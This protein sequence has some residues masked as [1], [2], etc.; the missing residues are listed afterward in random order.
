MRI[1]LM[2]AVAAACV[3]GSVW[4]DARTEEQAEAAYSARIA[5]EIAASVDAAL[6]DALFELE[7]AGLAREDLAEVRI[8]I[9][10]ARAEVR[11]ELAGLDG[12]LAG[13]DE[14]QEA[15][16][17]ARLEAAMAQVEEAVERAAAEFEASLEE[18]R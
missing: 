14:A 11:A 16:L 4:A 13:L 5:D 1:F 7:R 9:E 15:E 12:C 6:A 2:A 17:E 10:G 3:T 8:A 18:G